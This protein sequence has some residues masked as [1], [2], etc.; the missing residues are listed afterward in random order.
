MKTILS[1][2]ISWPQFRVTVKE[3]PFL[4]IVM[5]LVLINMFIAMFYMTSDS[6]ND[7]AMQ[8]FYA[9]VFIVLAYCIGFIFYQTGFI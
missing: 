6:T 1:R 4:I 5:L 9:S 3:F 8:Y 7:T 2:S